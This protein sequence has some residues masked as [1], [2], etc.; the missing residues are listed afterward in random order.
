MKVSSKS[1]IISS[2]LAIL[3]LIVNKELA[4]AASFNFSQTG[5]T[6]GGSITGM[7]FGEDK[8]DDDIISFSFNEEENEVSQYMLQWSGNNAVAPFSFVLMPD[9]V[10]SLELTYNV[11]TGQFN[12]SFS[13]AIEAFNYSSSTASGN[14]LV[15]STLVGAS[16]I[17]IQEV[18]VTQKTPEPSSFIG[19]LGVGIISAASVFKDKVKLSKINK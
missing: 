14:G 10:F 15:G 18:V 16:D 3:G 5:W 19:L 11:I 7:F 13:D 8:N 1:V 12:N 17:T 2:L 4:N 9:L 6:Q